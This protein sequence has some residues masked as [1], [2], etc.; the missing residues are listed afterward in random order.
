METIGNGIVEGIQDVWKGESSW[1]LNSHNKNEVK[2][3]TSN[4][5]KRKFQG[6]KRGRKEGKQVS[7]QT[8]ATTN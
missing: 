8:P 3:Y 2:S 5:R 1:K 4:K 7:E 6:R